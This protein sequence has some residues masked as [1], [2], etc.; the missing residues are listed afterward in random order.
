M[1]R[2]AGKRRNRYLRPRLYVGT[3]LVALAAASQARADS[4]AGISTPLGTQLNPAGNSLYL[5]NNP[6]GLSAFFQN[7][8]SPTGLLYPRPLF[9]PR[10]VQSQ[11]NR[12]WWSSAWA[13]IGYL[14]TAGNTGASSFR[15]YGDLSAGPVVNSAGFLAENRSS[16]F[17]LSA[18][19]GS[20]GRSDQTYQLTLGKY[21]VFSGTLFFDSI[22]HVFSTNA[23]VLWDGAGTGRLTL[24]PGL[25][26][27]A[28]TPNQVQSVL[29]TLFPG[30]VSLT[31]EKAGMALTYTP[32]ELSEV[33]V[34]FGYEDREGTRPL[35]ATFGYPFQNGATELVEPIEYRTFDVNAGA[36]FKGE[37]L[38]ANL[39]Y[40][41]SFFRNDIPALTWEKPGLWGLPA[42]PYIPPQG[43]MALPPDNDYHTVKGDLAWVFTRGRFAASA[44]YASMKQNAPLLPPTT[45]SALIQGV[46]GPIDLN[47]WNTVGALSRDS[48]LA[49]ISTFNGFAQLQFNP[50]S[51]LRLDFEVRSRNEDNKTNYVALNP[52]TGQYGYVA[53]DGGLSSYVPILSGVYEPT[54][55]GQRVQI[56]NIPFATDTL[57]LTAK[58]AYRLANR[59]RIEFAYAN[60][61]VDYSNREIGDAEDHRFSAQFVTRARDW[62]TVRVSYEFASVS[63]D[64]YVS[65][66]YVPFNSTSLPGYIPNPSG[67]AAFTLGP[68][69]KY[70]IADRTENTIKAQTN[71]ILSEKVDFQLGGNFRSYDYDADY[72]LRSAR[73]YNINAELTYQASLATNFNIF[74]SF[75]GHQ[76]D[77]ASINRVGDGPDDS[78]GGPIYPFETAWTEEADDKNH[79][80]GAGIRHQIN[81]VTIDVN[82]T[83]TYGDSSLNYSYASAGAYFS[84]VTPEEAGNAFPENT[85]RHHLLQSS[86]LWKYTQNIGVRGY[87]RF[88]HEAIEDFHYAGLTQ[89]VDNNIYLATI[90]ESYTAH[91]FGVFFQYSY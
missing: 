11:S 62:G 63:G 66:P 14:G 18:N 28:S 82:Y 83:F 8:R 10:M 47:N 4:A 56:R 3:A 21:G 73:N 61:S 74:Y 77:M 15:E 46:T 2:L 52:L 29:A 32:H 71:F 34:R 13:E 70:D 80:L 91:V 19:V 59:D 31:R 37:T 49:E 53:L 85:F 68:L 26:P 35:G 67:D 84:D 79:V 7:S 17:Y 90:P 25:T 50:T 86:V 69:R 55:A 33:F 44:S 58:A 72:G 76:R 48:A 40:A 23:R 60:K 57:T 65:N 87:Y 9:Y 6:M 45:G 16:A 1:T 12:D 5:P 43:Q 81:S 42:G 64:T 89:I 54:V 51:Q 36:R 22:P 38:Q 41:G 39:T 24:P 75:Q 88:E 27:G 30:E 20:V 78:A